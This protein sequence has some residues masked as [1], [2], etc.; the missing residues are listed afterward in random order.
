MPQPAETNRPSSPHDDSFFDLLVETLENVDE[1]VR[2]PFLQQFLKSVAHVDFSPKQSLET[3][4]EILKR[5]NEL[6]QNLGRRISLRTALVDVLVSASFLRVP[7]LM[8]YQDFKNLQWNAATDSLTGLYNRRLFEEYCDKELNRAQRYSQHL[9][10]T[11]LDLHL[12]KQ[13]ND[14]YGHM[15]GDQV[16]QLVAAS[17]RKNLR[18]SDFAFR[19]GGDEFA[20]LLP[21][22]DP[23]QAA[24][25]CD[26]LRTSFEADLAPL[27][28][29]VHATLDYGIAVYPQDGETKEGLLRLADDRLYRHKKSPR[30]NVRPLEEVR[31]R[32]TASSPSP[33]P[34]TPHPPSESPAPRVPPAPS[35]SEAAPPPLR[36]ESP[37]SSEHRKWE[38]ISLA[39]T[40]AYAV[41]AGEES[42]PA[43]VLDLCTGGLALSLENPE[44]LSNPFKAVL[45]VPILPPL[46]VTLRKVYAQKIDGGRSR[47]GCAF[48]S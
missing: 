31:P 17:L 21:Q 40:R 35:K 3:W 1:S 28:M 24:T 25:L 47:V 2:G 18:A 26:R 37:A 15:Q 10:L 45:H 30:T 48:V 14:R 5:R 36:A 44:G 9:A 12:L 19:I 38:R 13:V 42:K 41:I 20:L 22:S 29:D 43:S 4:S 6:S 33:A 32:P 16:L 23:E 34:V 8:E 46:R 27:Q 39:G 7:V 11:L